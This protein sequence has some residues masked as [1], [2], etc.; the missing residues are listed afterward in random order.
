MALTPEEIIAAVGAMNE[1]QKKA[2]KEALG[3]ES[4]TLSGTDLQDQID[5]LALY[6]S[7][8]D[9]I[10]DVEEMREQQAE[11]Q[12]KLL[13]LMR[14]KLKEYK[15]AALL[16]MQQ[17]GEYDQEKIKAL[18]DQMNELQKMIDET[19]KLDK[20]RSSIN[21]KIDRSVGLSAEMAQSAQEWGVALAEGKS[22]MLGVSNALNF[23]MKQAD[24]FWGKMKSGAIDMIFGV[25]KATKAFQRQFQFSEKYNS[26]LVRQYKNMNEY[27]VSIDNVTAAHGSLVQIATDFTMMTTRQQDLLSSTAALA[28]EQ[29]VAFDD[30]ARGAQA[31]MKFFGESASGA[32]RV[33][34]ELLSTAKALGVAP[35]QLSAQF[36][37]MANQFAKFGDEGVRA[38]KDVA[39]ISKLTG[40]EM[41]KVL[42]LANKFDTF[43][44]AAEM[45]GKLNAALGG[46]FVNAMDMMMATDPA[47][48]FNMI[49][50]SLEN[51]GLSFDD[52]SYYQK[53]FYADSLGLSDVGD[54]ALMMSGRMDLL[55]GATN[56]S[57]ESHIEMQ[58]RAQAS[59]NVMEAFQAIIQDN[60]EGL[61]GLGNTLNKITKYFLEN[62]HIV[63]FA[64]KAYLL[65]KG[66][67][68]AL[69][70]VH[71][72]LLAR[73]A[74][75]VATAALESAANMKKLVEISKEIAAKQS[76]VVVNGEV[77]VSN[78]AVAGSMAPVAPAAAGAAG[79]INAFASAMV[80]LGFAI[81]Q[82]GVGIG[83]ILVS[84]S[85]FA[86][87][88]GYAGDGIAKMFDAIDLKK[89]AAFLLFIGG[90]TAAALFLKVAAVGM[91][92]LAGGILAVSFSLAFISTR[93]LEAIATF[94]ESLSGTTVGN[95]NAV[96]RA[97]KGVAKA[98]KEIPEG[99][100]LAL[101][102]TM[103][104]TA[105]AAT[106]ARVLAG[107]GG[108]NANAGGA[109]YMQNQGGGS[110]EHTVN[111]TFNPSNR[112]LFD[113]E[114]IK[115]TRRDRGQTASAQANGNGPNLPQGN[116]R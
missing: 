17:D 2:I 1:A 47:E 66:T 104:A 76:L 102:M 49:R 82:V 93:K 61:V 27:G 53:K 34:R 22:T 67:L 106:A 23:A 108:G 50:E 16:Q 11:T 95:I 90:L 14:Q 25:D 29:G 52:M 58:E 13:E 33:S 73:R 40:F 101:T 91:A 42:A 21:D 46:N 109:L 26:M 86:A 41:E 68:I 97:I 88:M 6:K 24:G 89:S 85:L 37:S 62:G 19:E 71:G 94:T 9:Q 60:A 84:A 44:D 12:V 51:A 54:L 78:G 20:I 72:V 30:F 115:I 48:R 5:K 105:T 110:T 3:A 57:A 113:A 4:S 39:R 112:E 45:T 81:I 75:R 116:S 103:Q 55:S 114:V 63:K 77:V 10:K 35:G 18:T 32:D 99:R 74:A 28:G 80:K 38:F 8:L 56:E 43:E 15:D 100:A 7:A 111:I 31:S 87:A 64:I 69:N 70:V 92:V 65:L 36:G 107:A 79:G 98:M 59:M 96:T 83:I